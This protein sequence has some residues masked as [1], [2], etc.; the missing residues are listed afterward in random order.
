[1]TNGSVIRFK[2]A[3]TLVLML[4]FIFTRLAAADNIAALGFSDAVNL[5]WQRNLSSLLAQEKIS[6]AKG[7]AMSLYAEL[8]PQITAD[9]SQQNETTNLAGLGFEKSP[10]PGFPLLI[11]P[12]GAFDARLRLVQNL[13]DFKKL[14]D[15]A[16]GRA[17]VRLA[18]L[19]QALSKPDV[20]EQAALAYVDA[21]R[22]S[23]A[24]DAAK[25]DLDLAQNLFRLAEDEHGVGLAH[26]VDVAR[27]KTRVAEE[28]YKVAQAHLDEQRSALLLKRIIGLPLD[29]ET[30]LTDAL[31]YFPQDQISTQTAISQAM[32]ARVEI[33]VAKEELHLNR[34]EAQALEGGLLPSIS[35]EA[36]YGESGTDPSKNVYH[37]REVG[38]FVSLP[39]FNGEIYGR[40]KE[41]RSRERQSRL[42]LSDLILEVEK[43]VRLAMDEL[44]ASIDQ[45]NA[46]DDSLALA[47]QELS[48]AK[49]RFQSGV[50]DNL[51]VLSAQT[52]LENARQNHVAALAFYNRSRIFLAAALGQMDNFKL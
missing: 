32:G 46:A 21:Q 13:L 38:A 49:D 3:L 9:A 22:A 45:V 36:D 44:S 41:A 5:A 19:E 2:T 25:S 37:T 40:I 23:Q 50:A 26:G 17:K 30:V 18:K 24:V 16:A 33:A 10:F 14:N 8:W 48:M 43:E 12:F 51:E 35:A 31:R 15:A 6:E 20:A 47:Q 27:A 39:L 52:S 28:N 7:S 42:M 1:M 29:S 4:P 11:G 34:L